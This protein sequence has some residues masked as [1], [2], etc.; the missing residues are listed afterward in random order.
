M[1]L[2]LAEKA[3]VARLKS[4]IEAE[5]ETD[6]NAPA[7]QSFPENPL[8]HFESIN[9]KGEILVA[10]G[11]ADLTDPEPNRGKVVTQEITISW[12]IWVIH[13][14]LVQHDGVYS[15]ITAV[16]DALTNWTLTYTDQGDTTT[17]DDS[18]PF[19]LSSVDFLDQQSGNWFYE[20]VFKQI[21]EEGRDAQT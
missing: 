5:S 13:K 21:L 19:W 18:S 15:I 11:G 12:S 14:N 16:K 9:P 3:I 17:W 10:F 4:Q 6:F 1:D 20:L 7:I 8:Q 2:Q